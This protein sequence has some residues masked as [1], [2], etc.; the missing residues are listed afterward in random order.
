MTFD[1]N[2]AP[3]IRDDGRGSDARD[4]PEPPGRGRASLAALGIV[5]LLAIGALVVVGGSSS[6]Q[7]TEA[8]VAQI[9]EEPATFDNVRVASDGEVDELLTDR[10]LVVQGEE[11]GDELLLVMR[12]T[13]FI[14]GYPASPTLPFD[15]ARI[16]GETDVR[17]TGVV[18]EFDQE[19]MTDE[20]GIVLNDGLFERWEG[21]PSIIVD[22][23]ELE[24]EA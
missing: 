4:W 10:T 7:P 17:F 9:V 11:P 14:S 1:M 3:L 18:D 20:L 6:S 12:P 15:M 23:L 8:T 2:T 16:V 24:P 19:Q 21:Q 22:R 13:T 5:A